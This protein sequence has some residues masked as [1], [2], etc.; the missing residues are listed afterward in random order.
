MLANGTADLQRRQGGGATVA[1][2]EE[3]RQRRAHGVRVPG[4]PHRPDLHRA[5]GVLRRLAQLDPAAG[6]EQDNS[7]VWVEDFNRAHYETSST[8]P[9]ESMTTTTR[10][11]SSGV[12]GSDTSRTG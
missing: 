1:W 9:A 6:P 8:A 7:T 5:L 11:S 3:G 2:P 4:Q 12:L 10:R